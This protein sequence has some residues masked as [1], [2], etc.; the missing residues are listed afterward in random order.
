[1]A[2][3]VKHHVMMNEGTTAAASSGILQGMIVAL[4][5]NGTTGNVELSR[6][7]RDTD[8]IGDVAGIAGDDATNSG[9]TIAI[10]DPV[11]QLWYMRPARRLGDYLDE[12]ITNRTNWTD[13]GTAKRG[14]TVYS[15][16]GEFATDQYTT[17]ASAD[18]ATTDTGA[19]STPAIGAA[20]SYG[21]DATYQ[22]QLI[23]DGDTAAVEIVAFLTEGAA[24][25]SLL[26]FRWQ[27]VLN[28]ATL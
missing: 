26:A 3:R 8:G 17:A 27:P 6:A 15:V 20:W 14:I 23:D 10:V 5:A 22:G 28:A 16:G 13:S 21:A 2:L 7:R 25:N 9:N 24:V 12:L 18:A 11:D 19:A 1:M 4:R